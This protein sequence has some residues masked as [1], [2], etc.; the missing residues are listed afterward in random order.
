MIS[1]PTIPTQQP[2]VQHNP[3]VYPL[4]DISGRN[5]TLEDVFN[6]RVRLREDQKEQQQEKLGAGWSGAGRQFWWAGI[7]VVF[8]MFSFKYAITTSACIIN[9]FFLAAIVNNR[10]RVVLSTTGLRES[11]T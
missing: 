11:S 3:L 7:V 1:H 4:R 5:R 6:D 2:L 8:N 10:Q 9:N